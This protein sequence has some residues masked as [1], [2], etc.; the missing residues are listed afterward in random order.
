MSAIRAITN[1][2]KKSFINKEGNNFIDLT[3]FVIIINIISI[4]IT[5]TYFI[6]FAFHFEIASGNAFIKAINT[7]IAYIIITSFITIIMV[8]IITFIINIKELFIKAD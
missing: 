8:L 4:I 6:N 1:T 7:F 3:P 2:I 5:Y